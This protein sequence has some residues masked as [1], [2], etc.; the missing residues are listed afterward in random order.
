MNAKPLVRVLHEELKI[1]EKI[2]L[3]KREEQRWLAFGEA[4]ALLESAERLDALAEDAAMLED[5]RAERSRELA[6]SLGLNGGAKLN[7]ILA[8]M[9]PEERGELETAG[10]ALKEMATRV[11]NINQSNRVML[12]RAIETLNAQVNQFA[13]VKN[14]ETYSRNGSKV[15]LGAARAGLNVRA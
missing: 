6:E 12:Q 9:A 2:L 13:R 14:Q 4:G 1:Q 15:R 3:E 10:N 11:Q 5:E 7:E 8:A